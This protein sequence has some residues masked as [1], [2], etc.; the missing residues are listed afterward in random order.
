MAVVIIILAFAAQ[1]TEWYRWNGRPTITIE[2]RTGDAAWRSAESEAVAE[3]N[4]GS[5]LPVQYTEASSYNG[6]CQ[7]DSTIVGVCRHHLGSYTLADTW[8]QTTGG[9]LSGAYIEFNDLRESSQSQSHKLSIACHEVGH[10]LGLGEEYS[11]PHSCMYNG[12]DAFPL[13]PDANDFA[14][15][16]AM[17]GS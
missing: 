12:S 4:Q 11:D 3:W 8:P 15:L 7:F 16:R 10:A 13:G 1:A 5:P 9:Y 17:Y 6:Y 2:D 14:E